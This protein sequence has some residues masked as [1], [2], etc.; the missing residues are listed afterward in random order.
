MED[1][2]G[3]WYEER[4]GERFHIPYHEHATDEDVRR[5]LAEALEEKKMKI[6][7]KR[8]LV[9]YCLNIMVLTLVVIAL[10]D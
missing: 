5:A 4:N 9:L 3:G 6:T 2:E 7:D 1:H 8:M 10:L